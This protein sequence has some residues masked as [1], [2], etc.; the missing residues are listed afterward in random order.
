MTVALKIRPTDRFKVE[1]VEKKTAKSAKM[2][3]GLK[4]GKK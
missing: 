2:G 1:R 3:T 4:I